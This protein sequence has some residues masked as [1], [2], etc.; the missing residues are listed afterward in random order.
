M[1]TR[2]ETRSA[3]LRPTAHRQAPV[4]GGAGETDGAA[5]F[6]WHACLEAATRVGYGRL[7]YAALVKRALDVAIAG[8]ALALLS[9]LLLVVALAIR[10]DSRGPALFRQQRVGLGGRPFTVLK[11]RTMRVAAPGEEVKLF[12]AANGG[13]SHKVRNDPRVTRVG[14]VL[15]KTSLDELPQLVNVL[16]GEMSL[17]GPRPELVGIVERYEAW[18]HRRHLVRPGITGW[19]QVSGRSDKPLHENTELDLYYVDRL[20]FGLDLLILARTLKV[21]V[22]GSGAF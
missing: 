19:W 7:L 13:V 2:S 21:V 8:L 15:R 14:R 5:L 12:K 1:V 16:K 22:A 17:V 6:A 4:Q 18:Q 9:P 3:A 20:S 11:F 10:L